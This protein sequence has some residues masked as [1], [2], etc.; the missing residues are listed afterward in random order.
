MVETITFRWLVANEGISFPFAVLFTSSIAEESGLE[1]SVLTAI[2]EM[3]FKPIIRQ[4]VTKKILILL[5]S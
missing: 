2:C 3:A 4:I 1:P 5:Q